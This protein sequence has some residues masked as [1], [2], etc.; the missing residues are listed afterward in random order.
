MILYGKPEALRSGG[1][2][3]SARPTLN[4]ASK[5]LVDNIPKVDDLYF[6]RLVKMLPRAFASAL[7][8]RLGR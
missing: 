4:L 1:L 5:R 2:E 3:P 7:R 8:N 6:G